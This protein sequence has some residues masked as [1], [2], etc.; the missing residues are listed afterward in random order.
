MGVDGTD[1]MGSG[2]TGTTGSD[3]TDLTSSE[4]RGVTEVCTK[5]SSTGVVGNVWFG[6]IAL[7]QRH[8]IQTVQRPNYPERTSI[9]TPGKSCLVLVF[10]Y[11]A[12]VTC[13]YYNKNGIRSNA[14][15]LSILIIGLIA[16]PAVSL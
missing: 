9:E 1:A 13:R 11:C 16:G 2:E 6:S 15:I 7:N 3:G 5:G 14:T 12:L 10:M 4:G 8:K